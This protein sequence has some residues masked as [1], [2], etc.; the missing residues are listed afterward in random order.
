[1]KYPKW[2]IDSP[3]STREQIV[4]RIKGMKSLEAQVSAAFQ[5]FAYYPRNSRVVGAHVLLLEAGIDD[6]FDGLLPNAE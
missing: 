3:L 2:H 5:A 6:G 1:M 4:E